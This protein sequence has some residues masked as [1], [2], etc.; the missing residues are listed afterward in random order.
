MR[1]VSVVGAR[2]QFIKAAL[3]SREFSARGVDEWLVHT[4]QHYDKR[5]SDV[6][7]EEF[8]LPEPRYHLGVGSASHG[9]QTGEIMARLEPVVAEARP[10]CVLVYG[11]TNS[12]LGGALVGA[13]MHVPVVH[14]ESG[15]RSFDRSMPEEIN[16]LVADRISDLLLAPSASAAGQLRAEGID[17]PIEVVGDLMVDLALQVAAGLPTQPDVLRRFAVSSNAFALA[18]IHRASNTDD[19]HVFAQL[20]AG[21]RGLAM[22]VIFP[23]HPRTRPL[24]DALHVGSGDGIVICEPLSYADTLALQLH[25]RVIL[26]DSGGMQKEAVTLRTPCVTLRDTTEW[27]ETLEEDWNVLVGHDPQ[28]IVTAARRPLPARPI[29]PF[30]D[31]HCARRIVDAMMAHISIADR[32]QT[33]AS[34][35]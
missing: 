13:K 26:T 9:A 14:V 16:R 2:P 27:T 15:L 3:L 5:M 1:V 29:K 33:C 4:G 21:L 25:A 18:T 7:F 11:D 30:G 10:D 24:V 34:S 23:V 8:G 32:A 28:R 6:F 20:I 35:F 19:R 12:T 31:G 17:R 22:P